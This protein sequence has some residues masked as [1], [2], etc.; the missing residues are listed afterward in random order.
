MALIYSDIFRHG[1]CQIFC[2]SMIPKFFNFT[3]ERCVNRQKLRIEI[4][5]L[6]YFEQNISFCAIIYDLTP[7]V[8]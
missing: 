2:A 7:I 1:H 5:L 3:Q 6:I 4:V 8:L